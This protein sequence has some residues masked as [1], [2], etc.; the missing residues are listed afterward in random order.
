MSIRGVQWDSG[1]ALDCKEETYLV[2]HGD[3]S[4]LQQYRGMGDHLHSSNSCMSDDGWRMID[5]QFVDLPTVVPDGWTLLMCIGDYSPWVPVDE[6]LVK[7]LGLTKVCDTSQS[8]RRLQLF[9]LTCP[10]TF[11]IG[12][13]IGRDIQWQGI[14]R[15]GRKRPPD[16]SFFITYSMIG[17]DHQ[18]QTVEALDVMESILG[19]GTEDTSKV[20]TDS[21]SHWDEDGGIPTVILMAHQQLVGIGSDEL[22]NFPGDPRVHLVSSL[23]HLMMV[24]VAP[25]SNI[26]HSWMILRGIDGIFSMW[27]DR[28]SP[29]ILMIEYGDGWEDFGSIEI[30]LQVQL[31]DSRPNYHRYFKHEDPGVGDPVFIR[32]ADSHDQSS[33]VSA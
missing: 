8:Y 2:E 15:V 17:V 22:P 3:L 9:L 13:N 19:H 24:R 1:D 20:H 4:P 29:L 11:I 6:F 16:K 31:L 30:P 7:S 18:R 33:A 21:K 23:L 25:E 28:F 14:W 10:D 32:W 12:N 27:R 26:L 5:Q